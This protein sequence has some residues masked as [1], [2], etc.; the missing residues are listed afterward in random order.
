MVLDGSSKWLRK[1]IAHQRHNISKRLESV[2]QLVVDVV[3]Y[4]FAVAVAVL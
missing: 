3:S 1:A 2:K 4:A